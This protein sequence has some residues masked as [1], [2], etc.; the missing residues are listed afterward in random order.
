MKKIIVKQNVLVE[1]LINDENDDIKLPKHLVKSL[2][3]HKTSLGD[4]PAFPPED[5]DC[6]D[7]KIV[8]K[9]FKHLYDE[10]SKFD[11]I[12]E[13]SEE[14]LTNVLGK[15]VHECQKIEKPLKDNLEKLC[16]NLV[17]DLFNIPKDSV[18]FSCELVDR[19]DNSGKRLT[20]E[21]TDDIEVDGVEDLDRLSKEVYKRRLVNSLIQGAALKYSSDIQA[22]VKEIYALNYKL[23]TLY[24][25]I[26][27]INSFL[28]FFKADIDDEKSRTDAGNVDVHLGNDVEQATIEAKGIIF[29]ILLNESFRGF[30]EL[31]A[32]HGLPEK[33][34]DALYVIKKSDFLLA[35]P[36]DMRLGYS[37]WEMVSDM[38]K[39]DSFDPVE[40]GIPFIFTE[41]VS[42]PADEF[43]QFMKEIFA[44]TKKGK[45]L[46][47]GMINFILHEKEKDDFDAYLDDKNSQVAVIGDDECFLPE[48]LDC[49]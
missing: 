7:Y 5:E 32:A 39:I 1:G 19:I 34:E 48:E 37:L 24:E 44:K 21:K 11:D 28:L 33:R 10:L 9:R 4:H 18:S 22:F 2:S 23:P 35:E 36:W 45:E 3:N 38:I 40:V 20:P 27:K 30:L 14:N 13:L 12:G 15:L 31:F 29:P 6:F 47:K 46:M 8:N 25:K 26:T 16:T 43:H 17:N 42:L 41:L 49:I